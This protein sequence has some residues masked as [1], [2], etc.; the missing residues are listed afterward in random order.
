MLKTWWVL[1]RL[2][3]TFQL[4]CPKLLGPVGAA[5]G[6]RHF[7]WNR[8]FNCR[9]TQVL[10]ATTAMRRPFSSRT[11]FWVWWTL[12]FTTR[13]FLTVTIR[14]FRLKSLA[15]KRTPNIVLG[16]ILKKC[17]LKP[18]TGHKNHVS[19]QAARSMTPMPYRVPCHGVLGSTN[20]ESFFEDIMR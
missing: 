15:K 19:P 3:P 7:R 1:F 5:F 6:E 13:L 18:G 20:L 17:D 12:G 10:R 8:W 16:K 14:L 2:A 11:P 9:L 4:I